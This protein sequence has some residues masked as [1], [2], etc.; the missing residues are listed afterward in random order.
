MNVDEE[1]LK[2]SVPTLALQLILENIF[3]HNTISDSYKMNIEVGVSDNKLYIQNS[4]KEK[5]V[6]G[7]KSGVGISNL[8]ER[9]T[10]FTKDTLEIEDL[11]NTYRISIPLL[12]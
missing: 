3:K 11:D 4:K 7:R 9:Y 2:Y 6:F 10:F 5:K 1:F 12:N 8:R